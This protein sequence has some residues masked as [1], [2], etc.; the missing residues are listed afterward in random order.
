MTTFTRIHRLPLCQLWGWVDH[1]GGLTCEPEKSLCIKQQMIVVPE[2]LD[3]KVQETYDIWFVC[4]KILKELCTFIFNVVGRW[5][6]AE[7]L[8]CVKD[9]GSRSAVLFTFISLVITSVIQV[10]LTAPLFFLR[11]IVAV[12]SVISLKGARA[13]PKELWC[14][15]RLIIAD[16]ASRMQRTS[17]DCV[18]YVMLSTSPLHSTQF[19]VVRSVST[20]Y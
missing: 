11:F 12:S 6:F 10:S 4:L 14:R 8:L 13:E 9:C 15:P 16:C 20:C 18:W 2:Y 3:G 1:K 19:S 17:K 5:V 7:I